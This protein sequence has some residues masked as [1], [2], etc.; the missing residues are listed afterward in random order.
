MRIMSRSVTRLRRFTGLF[1]GAGALL[2]GVVPASGQAPTRILTSAI[3]VSRNGAEIELQLENGRELKL[4]VRDDR[5]YVDGAE[6]GAAPRNGELD[7]SWRDLLERAVEAPSGE[8][9]L[10]LTEWS[11]PADGE[12]GQT[13]DDALETALAGVPLAPQSPAPAVSPMSD[14][15]DRL[16]GRI[17]E[18]EQELKRRSVSSSVTFGRRERSSAAAADPSSVCGVA[19]RAS[20]PRS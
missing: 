9:A 17:S 10:L 12:G 7:R 19:S 1:A 14:S 15:V 5:A 11:P 16:V 2:I 8:L 13:L 3:W 20:F 6:V 18:L 4:A